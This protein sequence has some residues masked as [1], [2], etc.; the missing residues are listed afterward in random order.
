MVSKVFDLKSERNDSQRNPTSCPHETVR[1]GR[2]LPPSSGEDENW[3]VP[4]RS[5]RLLQHAG[6]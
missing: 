2:A 5:H 4:H 3:R 1:K 6:T